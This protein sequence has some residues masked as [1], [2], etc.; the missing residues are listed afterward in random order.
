MSENLLTILIR[1]AVGYDPLA[2]LS[3]MAQTKYPPHNIS[4]VGEKYFIQLAVAGFS[5]GELDVSAADGNLTIKGTKWTGE[6]QT[7]GYELLYSGIAFRDFERTWK[8]GEYVEVRSVNLADGL[9]TVTLERVVPEE[10][11]ARTFEI[12]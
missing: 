3:Q 10:K 12:F 11:K 5:K 6:E 2:K 1:D 9:L 7:E 8:L 4:K